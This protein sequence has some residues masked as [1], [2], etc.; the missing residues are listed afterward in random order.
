MQKLLV[1]EWHRLTRNRLTWVLLIFLSV[2]C[3]LA[4]GQGRSVLHRQIEARQIASQADSASQKRVEDV[5]NEDADPASAILAPY[6]VSK[7]VVSSVPPLADFSVGRAPH[8]PHSTKVS[9]RSRGD[10]LFSR[11]AIDNPELAAR[12]TVDLGFVAVVLL[13]LALIA[14]GYN[15]FTDDRE[16]GTARLILNEGI[17]PV[18]MLVARSVPRVL[19]AVAP[20][21]VSAFILVSVGPDLD[22]RPAAVVG[23]VAIAVSLCVFW[24]SLIVLTNTFDI[25]SETAALALVSIW[26]L[27]TLVFPAAISAV[28]EVAY[29]PPSRLEQIVTARAVQ[30]ASTEAYENDHPETVSGGV[31]G[32]LA[33]I[34]K[35]LSI[36]REVDKALLP[37]ADRFNTQLEGQQRLV[38]N[39]SLLSPPMVAADAL[40]A[41]AG[42]DVARSIEFHKAARRYLAQLKAALGDVVDRGEVMSRQE[43][44]QLPT[45]VWRADENQPLRS[46]VLLLILSLV[47]FG[48][49]FVRLRRVSV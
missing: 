37:I 40:T 46:A 36:S 38:R 2:A 44:D 24:W 48:V 18:G 29:P 3:L 31:E 7:T 13:P 27:F 19:L 21:L 15:L 30:V 10:T 49:S 34:R 12:G 5:L 25:T 26:A 43:Y 45:F 6:W 23:W 41:S 22:G 14:F 16:K 39:L 35:S 28:A 8:E 42:T 9:L 4:I 32:R 17:S 47:L 11:T 33:S 1:L 20:I